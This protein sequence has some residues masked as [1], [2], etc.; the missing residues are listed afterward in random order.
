MTRIIRR[1]RDR[2]R[3]LPWDEIA[4]VFDDDP[5]GDEHHL[6]PRQGV[7]RRAVRFGVCTSHRS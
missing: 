1:R 5:E 3:A 4:G 7:G 2:R 6:E